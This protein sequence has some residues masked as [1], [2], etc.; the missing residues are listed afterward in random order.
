MTSGFLDSFFVRQIGWVA[1]PNHSL[2]A[3][4][5]NE[6]PVFLPADYGEANGVLIHDSILPVSLKKGTVT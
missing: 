4:H 2:S 1:S 6:N 3:N 5:P